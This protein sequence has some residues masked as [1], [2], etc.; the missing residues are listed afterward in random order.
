MDFRQTGLVA[1]NCS[2]TKEQLSNSMKKDDF[3]NRVTNP[4]DEKYDVI[5]IGSG[6]GGLSCGAFLAKNGMGVKVFERHSVP[7]GYCTSFAR[8]GFKFSAAVVYITW[9]SPEGDVAKVLSELGLRGQIE[10]RKIEP[11]CKLLLPGE[12]FVIPT[13]FNEWADMLSI[14]FPGE[15]GGIV[16]FLHTV[17]A[18]AEDMKKM[19]SPSRVIPRYQDKT[20]GEM[21]DEYMMTPR[22]KAV[23]SGIF[24]GGLPPSRFSALSWCAAMN[25]RITD[26]IYWPVGGAQAVADALVDGLERFGGHLELNTGVRKILVED[27]KAVG[28]ET[29]DG[30]RVKA[31]FV[32]S[33][34]A[35]RQTFGGLVSQ[36]EM[37]AVAPDFIDKLR[38]LETAM[39]SMSVY[40]GV[41]LNL[42]SLG[43]TNF[44]TLVHESLDFEKEWE[45]ANQG[46][47]ADSFFSVSIPTLHDPSLAPANKHII[48][49]FTYAPYYL[50]GS[51]WSRE[52]KARLT[53]V[54]IHKAEQVVPS[55]SKH[56]VVQDAA[57]PRTNERYTLNT[58]GAT[59]GWAR[60][61]ADLFSRPNPKTAIE[62]LYLTGHWTSHGGS[63]RSVAISGRTVAQM[64][65]S[66]Q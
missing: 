18:I 29:T 48:H 16:R 7:G 5:V 6:I 21:M 45:A 37:A 35:V 20:L 53:D 26:G 32:V 30:R 27:G 9:C 44:L 47:L 51:D 22:L 25:N 11:L 33:N 12:S 57:T 17:Q 31:S 1:R 3:M 28:V 38:G 13:G 8:K 41:D 10:F 60:S 50:P 39:S 54:M 52:E 24:Y 2:R 19:P 62:R 14:D 40:L 63:I 56:I 55:L 58:E 61:P 66:E 34:A 15:R 64:I 59:A 65:M 49:I 36:R 46:K 42:E 23:I 43:V 4:F